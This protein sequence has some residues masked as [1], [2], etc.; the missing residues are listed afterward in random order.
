[1]AEQSFDQRNA[2]NLTGQMIRGCTRPTPPDRV[3]APDATII[4]ARIL[5]EL[6]RDCV[7]PNLF[8][9]LKA[10]AQRAKNAYLMPTQLV[11]WRKLTGGKEII[12][13]GVDMEMEDE[14]I[15]VARQYASMLGFSEKCG[16]D[17]HPFCH[18]ALLRFLRHVK[19]TGRLPDYCQP[20]LELGRLAFVSQ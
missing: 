20:L 17:I 14:E 8:D 9:P 18:D 2:Q 19:D 6:R 12:L 16:E 10:L 15:G 7:T 11:C 13:I 1:M 4:P 5:E 3:W